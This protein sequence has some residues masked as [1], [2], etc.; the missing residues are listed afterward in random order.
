MA[1]DGML[2]DHRIGREKCYS[3]TLLLINFTGVYPSFTDQSYK[4][5][6]EAELREG[7]LWEA[8]HGRREEV[9][10][11]RSQP[12]VITCCSQFSSQHVIFRDMSI[13]IF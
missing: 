5:P 10:E 13:S 11:L 6:V 12:T 3:L 4:L 8:R 7:N 1:F 9:E 2:S